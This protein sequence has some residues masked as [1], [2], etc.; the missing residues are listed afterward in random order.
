MLFLREFWQDLKN[1]NFFTWENC[2]F[3]NLSVKHCTCLS[4]VK[5]GQAVTMHRVLQVRVTKIIVV[6]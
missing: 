1:L 5:D 4:G 2:V 6:C 3:G